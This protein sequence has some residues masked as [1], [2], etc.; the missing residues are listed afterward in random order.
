MCGVRGRVGAMLL[1]VLATVPDAAGSVRAAPAAEIPPPEAFRAV[2]ERPLFRPDRRPVPVAVE[3][4]VP[5]VLRSEPPPV[6]FVGTLRRGARTVALVA[7]AS[8]KLLEL[9]PGGEVA[10]WRVLVVEPRRLVLEKDGDL[11]EYRLRPEGGGP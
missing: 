2:V 9:A 3:P 11:V 6:T 7:G 5:P 10:G 4:D 8:P 1:A